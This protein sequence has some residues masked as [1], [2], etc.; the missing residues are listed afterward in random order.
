MP[1]AGNDPAGS[2]PLTF[3]AFSGEDL[4]RVAEL[5][6][7]AGFNFDNESEARK[8]L[9][10]G[11]H[12]Q[13]IVLGELGGEVV[14][15]MDLIEGS[16]SRGRFLLISRLVISPPHRQRGLGRRFVEHAIAEGKRRGCATI[17]LYVSVKNP[18]AI[19]LYAA[20]GFEQRDV[21]IHMQLALPAKPVPPTKR[22]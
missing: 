6:A 9:D 17:D 7:Q 1:D 5:N 12:P 14:G 16:S 19:A 4:P 3:R 2:I 15:K 21:D 18:R 10:E 11:F 22:N 13:Q 8:H 20:S